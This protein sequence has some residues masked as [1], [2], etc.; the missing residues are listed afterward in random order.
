MAPGGR[1]LRPGDR[2]PSQTFAAQSVLAIQNAQ[3][4]REIDA[5]SQELES[6]SQN[7][8]QLYR[9]STA[10]QEPLSL[11]E[12][13]TRVLDA[14]RQVVRLDRLYSWTLT[15]EGDGLAVSAGAGFTESDW[16]PMGRV[17]PPPGGRGHGRRLPGAPLHRAEPAAA[18][19]PSPRTL[20]RPHRAPRQASS[21]SR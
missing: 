15:P 10:L 2:E 9:L 7:M 20:L 12:Q 18:G 6:L 5:K 13:L 16:R 11:G 21:S 19:A 1:E 14:A 4:F 17:D 3:L 8:D